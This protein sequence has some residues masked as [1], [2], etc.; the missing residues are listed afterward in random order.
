MYLVVVFS[1]VPLSSRQPVP[2]RGTRN[3]GRVLEL[4]PSPQSLLEASSL[5]EM[6][7]NMQGE[8]L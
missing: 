1:R 4:H 3:L 5:Q 2:Y 7:R 6:N 8:P